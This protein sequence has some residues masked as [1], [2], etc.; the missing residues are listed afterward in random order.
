MTPESTQYTLP[1]TEMGMDDQPK[2]G[3]K[4]ASLGEMIR[5]LK[6]AGVRIPDGFATTSD[7]YRYFVEANKLEE[8]IRENLDKYHNGELEIDEA[9]RNI[10]QLF[11]K[12][13]FPTA[14]AESIREA[15]T[16]LNHKYAEQYD[17]DSDTYN[18]DVAVRSS[19]TAEDLPGASFAGQQETYLNV[20]G[21]E[22]LM[23]ACKSCFASLFTNRAIVYRD[24]KDFGHMDVALSVGVQKMVR[25]DNSCSGVLFTVDTETGFP[26]A[27]LINGAWG[28]GENV[29]KGTVNPDQY[30]VFKNRLDN[31]DYVPI[32]D[33]VTGSKEMKMVYSGD[34]GNTTENVPTSL[35]E[36]QQ[37]VLEDEEIIQLAKW[38]VAIEKHYDKPMD[39]EWVKED[40]TKQIYIVQA[41]PETVHSLKLNGMLK[42]YRLR[43]NNPTLL[44]KG[45]SV[46]SVITTGTVKVV[47]DTSDLSGIEEDTILVTEMTEP[48]WVPALKNAGG[49]VTDFGGRTCHAAIVS[50]ELGIPAVVGTD[51]ATDELKDGD[52][53]T[54]SSAEGDVG[55]I[56]KGLLEYK[57]DEVDLGSL[58]K[59]ETEVMLNLATPESAFKWWRLPVKGVGLARMEFII[60]NHIRIHPM[61]LVHPDQVEDEEAY[62]KIRKLT[63][64]YSDMK[65]YFVDKLASGISKIAASRF[66]DPVIVRT[67]DFKSNEYAGLIGGEGFEPDEENPMIGWRG[68]SRYYHENYREGF[69]LECRA[70]KKVREVIGLDNVIVMIP[71][72]RTLTEAEKVLEVMEEYGLKR[73]EKGLQI[74]MMCEIPSNYILADQF[75]EFFDGFSIG[76]NDLTQLILGV[77]RDS[78]LMSHVFDENDPAVK[79]AI[80]EVVERAHDAG[81]KVGFCGQ[82]PSNDPEYAAFLVE[83]GIDSVSVVPDS[84][85]RVIHKVA[86]AEGKG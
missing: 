85:I 36:R 52:K 84:V 64:G 8:P 80:R 82:A 63:T 68:A 32:I 79:T 60:S 40:K 21:V 66:P 69:E 34:D 53:I 24:K 77:D 45:Q 59:P 78:G 35:A 15:Y 72:C 81:I 23:K 38:G 26:N 55:K 73:G 30:Y 76:S 67:S 61:A 11:Q 71:F 17:E 50:R 28:L 48:D 54:L 2:V 29:V 10:R 58:P 33:K 47:R 44:L 74:Y 43:E 12:S 20:R 51:K 86:E 49:I 6:S 37:M 22:D 19:A 31:P 62:R 57:V 3:G 65:E 18:A 70:L 9:G 4:N 1:F 41:R 14:L 5:H 46:G 75:A 13:T 83:C 27:L 56:Y 42:S 25:A 7:A 39:I 16:E